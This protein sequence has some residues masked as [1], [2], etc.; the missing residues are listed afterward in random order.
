MVDMIIVAGYLLSILVLGLWGGRIHKGLADYAT[1][2][3]EFGALVIFAT[4]SA[5]FIGGG[6]S[7]GNAEKVFVYGVANIVALW[8]FSCKEL[9][10]AT[11]IAP[12]M[13]KFPNA[14]S[15][16]DIMSTTY[17]KVARLITG[18]SGLM[19]CC[20]IIGAQVGAIGVVFNVFF[21]MD[22]LLGIAVGCSIVIVYTT[23]GG[24]R[25]VIYTDVAQFIIL[26]IGM[27]LALI[28]GIYQIGG[29]EA[30]YNA[31][32]PDRWTLPGPAFDWLGL[33]ALVL[34]FMF[35]ETLVP[36]YMQ[37]LLAGKTATAA[38]RG[39]L[40]AGLFSFAFFAVTGAIGLVA[41]ALAPDLDPN[42]AMPY[43]IMTVL[44]PVL[45]G[46]VFSGV[47]AIIMSTADSYLNSASITFV[48]DI[49]LPLRS[50]PL[51]EE[52]LLFLAKIATLVVGVLSILFAISI[53]SILDILIY[54]Y[55]YWAPIILVPLVNA[56]YGLR[57][58]TLPFLAG[59][60]A[61]G[62]TTLV[63][64]SFLSSPGD[65]SGLVLGVLMNLLVFCLFPKSKIWLES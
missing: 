38:A 16:G 43:V 64:Q 31:V 14:V 63:W 1:A 25:A 47:I 60:T 33:V 23:L 20:G 56:I 44:P 40:Y 27:P 4:M 35:G 65:I 34:V 52:T 49:L 5:S 17:G 9:L 54:A 62:L 7:T 39:T 30:L 58:G 41:L 10:V 15:V 21:G 53:E 29:V 57:K 61:G 59:A 6:Y 28:F 50:K 42:K 26:A 45:K 8:G 32:P 22:R 13:S 11:F 2:G 48:K 46:F 19:L 3:R 36:P 18:I 12:K 55:N 24:M 51:Q 37:R